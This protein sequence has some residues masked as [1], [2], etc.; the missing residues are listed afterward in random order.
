MKVERITSGRNES[1]PCVGVIA[2]PVVQ[3]KPWEGRLM[4]NL[5]LSIR[6]IRSS[7]DVCTLVLCTWRRIDRFGFSFKM[8][9]FF[10]FI[11]PG[12][13]REPAARNR[14][15]RSLKR[16]R[17]GAVGGWTSR[18]RVWGPG[19][20]NSKGQ[21][22]GPAFRRSRLLKRTLR[23]FFPAK[24]GIAMFV[25]F[26]L[27]VFR[28]TRKD[29]C[30]NCPYLETEWRGD[31][32]EPGP[33]LGLEECAER[34]CATTRVPREMSNRSNVR[35]IK[36]VHLLFFRQPRCISAMIRIIVARVIVDP[37]RNRTL[38]ISW[39]PGSQRRV[40]EIRLVMQY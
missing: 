37:G 27:P 34:I 14:S 29:E 31:F 39:D 19:N 26:T 9:Q 28:S 18:C 25:T 11:G 20:G 22:R 13:P 2:I 3:G 35:K 17:R 32:L 5:S 15:G 30:H 4:K 23:L 7:S 33:A 36:S 8:K 1:G 40:F 10:V 12:A 38:R 6:T 21:L 24:P 16:L